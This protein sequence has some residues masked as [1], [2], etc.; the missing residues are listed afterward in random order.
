VTSD[1]IETLRAWHAAQGLALD[2]RSLTPSWT[3]EP[4]DLDWAISVLH[5]LA[6]P[7]GQ[8]GELTAG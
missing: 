1:P 6:N 3:G 7:P 2:A 4:L 8:M 5:P